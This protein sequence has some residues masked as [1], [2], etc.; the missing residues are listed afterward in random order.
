MD[1]DDER[2]WL[3]ETRLALTFSPMAAARCTP[4]SDTWH[5]LLA[6]TVRFDAP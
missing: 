6:Q 1:T 2:A 3:L 5:R 4:L